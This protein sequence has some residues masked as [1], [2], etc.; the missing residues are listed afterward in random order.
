MDTLI[1]HAYSWTTEPNGYDKNSN[2]EI[3]AWCLDQD[4]VPY[5]LRFTDYPYSAF[6]EVPSQIDGQKT[7]FKTVKF[8]QDVLV[9]YYKVADF[10]YQN[11]KDIVRRPIF[12][13]SEKNKIMIEAAFNSQSDMN[14]CKSKLNKPVRINELNCSVELKIWETDID[15][16][17]KLLT[18]TGVQNA[19]WLSINGIKVNPDEKVSTLE[20][21]YYVDW[22]TMIPRPDVETITN[23]RLLAFDIE[24]YSDNPKIFPDKFNPKHCAFM[25]SCLYQRV[26]INESR[27]RYV[28]IF[29][30]SEDVEEAEII[31]VNDEIELITKFNYLI[32]QL[33]PEI[34]IGYN[35][36]KFDIPYLNA[37]LRSRMLNWLDC[38][39]IKGRNSEMSTKQWESSAYGTQIINNLKMDGRIIIDLFTV[40]SRDHKLEKYDLTTVGKRFL[41]RGKHDVKPADM[42]KAFETKD[43]PLMTRVLKY[44]IED[45]E[46][47]IDLFEVLGLW[48]VL[49]EMS[50]IIGI[51]IED[52]YTRGQQIR[53]LTKLYPYAYNNK[54]VINK[55]PQETIP[56]SGGQVADPIVGLHENGIGID[57]NSLYPSLMRAYNMCLCTFILDNSEDIP[58]EMCNVF[59]FEENGEKI[60]ERC[61][62]RE[63]RHGLIPQVQ[64]ELVNKRKQVRRTLDG[65]RGENGEWIIPPEKDPVKKMLKDVQQLQYKLC[66]NSIYGALSAVTGKLAL[67][68]LGRCVTAMGRRNITIVG[69]HFVNKYGAKIIYG[70]TDSVFVDFGIKDRKEA[71]NYGFE[72]AKEAS[73][74]FPEDELRFEFE[75]CMRILCL[76]K[77]RYAALF[78]DKN[79]DFK[80]EKSGDY[81][82]F[83]RGIV[84]SRRDNTKFMKKLYSQ[85]LKMILT[86]ATLKDVFYTILNHIQDL[87]DDKV[88]IMD[89]TT[90]RLVN[91]NYKSE[92]FFMKVFV[93]ELKKVGK[94]VMPNERIEFVVVDSGSDVL[95]EKLRTLEWFYEDSKPIDKNYYITSLQKP[96]DQLFSIGFM[97]KLEPYKGVGLKIRKKIIGL[98]QPVMLIIKCLENGLSIQD[99][100]KWFENNFEK[101]RTLQFKPIEK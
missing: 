65:V 32:K 57:A 89:L 22:I 86:E 82:I 73:D 68:R 70:D 71:Y 55:I 14:I 84:L 63:I 16:V 8:I 52:L 26:G 24:V 6:I 51:C 36:M 39:R 78:V 2:L 74:L 62:K 67:L 93:D 34:I 72:V 94:P 3:N 25:I 31:R 88:D 92:S 17:T 29:G 7:G 61:V 101:Q 40:I 4:S 42:F 95:G 41:G 21:E 33:D 1:V 81:Y 13:Y 27:K 75:K 43:I 58:D 30:E 90:T 48:I 87:L 9:K 69:D 91:A 38:G 46:L 83:T 100:K 20:N 12:G 50:N 64:E 56:F 76:K 77:K 80:R 97:K 28:I 54:Y 10:L 96:I 99:I 15:V 60:K 59:E 19:Q 11:Q 53:G 37:R 5:L 49:R 44:C 18:K 47:L 66:A 35:I 79:G 23:P 45:S 98:D 85:C